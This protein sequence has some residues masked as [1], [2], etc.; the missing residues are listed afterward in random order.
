[1]GKKKG[2]KKNP[3]PEYKVIFDNNVLWGNPLRKEVKELVKKWKRNSNVD[4]E[5]LLPEVVQEEFKKSYINKVEE[6]QIQV[7]KWT[8]LLANFLEKDFKKPVIASSR[9]DDK[10][11]TLLKNNGFTIIP[12]PYEKIKLKELIEK[13]VYYKQPFQKKREKGFKDAVIAQ[14]VFEYLKEAGEKVKVVF[15]SGDENLR[16]YIN[17]THKKA[18]YFKSYKSVPDFE[19]DLKL[20]LEKINEELIEKIS[21]KA[22]VMFYSQKKPSS[23][24]L[25]KW[26]LI[27][28]I[29]SKYS[30]IFT[31]PNLSED[32][33]GVVI[34]RGEEKP[35][36][37][38]W[39]P[40]SDGKF[41]ISAPIFIEK[42]KEEKYLWETTMV[43]IRR[44]EE[45]LPGIIGADLRDYIAEFKIKW[46][47]DV[48]K[49][50]G[51]VLNPALVDI[52]HSSS[53][54]KQVFLSRKGSELVFNSTPF[55][56]ATLAG[57]GTIPTTQVGK[58]SRAQYIVP[59]QSNYLKEEEEK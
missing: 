27:K 34:V 2:K 25:V 56:G 23:S 52:N 33:G 48:N 54:T 50:T 41:E 45:K 12:T 43:Y 4:I 35:Y 39:N 28:Q 19:S 6:A 49:S 59:T 53:I 57:Q 3:L 37:S 47:F 9:L 42:T 7:N 55:S 13:A 8:G 18:K 46:E 10:I 16:K 20:H 15:I 31:E 32:L 11:K 51:D 26:N 38:E 1:M 40:V 21:K 36:E 14:T 24:L 29:D 5:F 22:K 58:I 30:D 17:H 44:Y